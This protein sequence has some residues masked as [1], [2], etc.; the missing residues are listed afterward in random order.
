M[1]PG[2]ARPAAL[3]WCRPRAGSPEVTLAFAL[4][5]RRVHA[6]DDGLAHARRRDQVQGL[7]QGAPIVLGDEHGVGAV[8]GD[9]D[10]L[11]G[12]DDLAEQLVQELERLGGGDGIHGSLL[13]GVGHVQRSAVS[14]GAWLPRHVHCKVCEPNLAADSPAERR[15]CPWRDPYTPRTITSTI[16]LTSATIHSAHTCT[17]NLWKPCN[18][19]S[20]LK[21]SAPVAH[22]EWSSISAIA[23]MPR[24]PC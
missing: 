24:A 3:A 2:P 11:V 18:T 17:L 7:V 19:R 10:R 13:G 6:L 16:P 21:A 12:L 8:A 1:P 23:A 15:E 5:D 22:S 4:L 20:R 14:G 9:Q